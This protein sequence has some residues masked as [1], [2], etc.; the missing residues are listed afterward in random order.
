MAN[1]KLIW[2]LTLDKA[3]LIDWHLRFIE[4]FEFAVVTRTP[5]GF[6]A[7]LRLVMFADVRT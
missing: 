3:S 1:C 4:V 2:P 5:L 7:F 6:I